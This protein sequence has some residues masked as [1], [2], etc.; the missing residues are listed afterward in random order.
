MLSSDSM[1]SSVFGRRLPAPLLGR[2]VATG[3]SAI[4]LCRSGM[5]AAALLLLHGAAWADLMVN[6]TRIVFD[7]N[8]R[9]AQV[10]LVNDGKETATYRI[11]LVNKRMSETGEFTD[12]DAPGPGEQFADSLLRYSPRQ[13]V[14]APGEAQLVRISLRKPADLAPGEYRSHL[15]FQRIAEPTNTAGTP[16]QNGSPGDGLQ[17]RLIPLIGVS[18]P[19]IVRHGETAATVTLANLE[20]QKPAAGEP[21]I[22]ALE[23]HRNGNRS[24]YGD[25]SVSFT[26]NGGGERQ[27]A[28]AYGVAVY[29][30]NPVRRA[31]IALQPFAAT[32]GGTLHVFFRERAEDGGKPLADATLRLP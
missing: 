23:L 13:V 19:I 30:P 18:I 12:I 17:I 22:L 11:G 8:Q 31:K 21:P 7:K 6:P 3:H 20:L 15:V 16:A 5:I 25:L 27:V 1:L 26:P 2:R 28:R 24:I 10:D 14:L 9:A 32:A 4:K 29:T